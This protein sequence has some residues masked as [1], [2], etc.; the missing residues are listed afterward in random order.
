MC[1]Y[2][3]GMCVCVPC[4]AKQLM[5]QAECSFYRYTCRESGK[6]RKRTD[7]KRWLNFCQTLKLIQ[8][9][10]YFYFKS[11]R[12]RDANSEKQIVR[13]QNDFECIEFLCQKIESNSIWNEYWTSSG[14]YRSRFQ[15]PIYP[16]CTLAYTCM[17]SLHRQFLNFC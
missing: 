15:F 16:L 8:M 12:M 4:G 9:I 3:V 5:R 14:Y 10:F 2:N 11:E 7:K 1:I 13:L 17:H 6:E